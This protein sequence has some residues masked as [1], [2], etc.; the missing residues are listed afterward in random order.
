MA[1][2]VELWNSTVNLFHSQPWLVGTVVLSVMV[3]EGL[4]LA[5]TL[6]SALKIFTTSTRR[7][8]RQH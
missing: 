2:I 1:Y 3:M 6:E 4:V 5:L 7:F 8:K